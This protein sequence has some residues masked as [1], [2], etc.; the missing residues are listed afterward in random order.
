M[1]FGKGMKLLI[2]FAVCLLIFVTVVAVTT[3]R[4]TV[5]TFR[6]GMPEFTQTYL[7]ID[8][9]PDNP[10]ETVVEYRTGI[11]EATSRENNRSIL[12]MLGAAVLA[13]GFFM[14]NMLIGPEGLK[15]LLHEARL[16]RNSWLR[17]RRPAETPRQQ[18]P[19]DDDWVD[20]V[21]R[22][23]AAP[24]LPAPISNPWLLPA[25]AQSED[26]G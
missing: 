19:A 17:N 16:L 25:Q 22:Q 20:Y 10:A 23:P 24:Q 4:E 9:L 3:I 2:L 26:N 11:A 15:G 12:L 18:R 6:E 21:H 13:V 14:A 1:M 8:G 5:T 7:L